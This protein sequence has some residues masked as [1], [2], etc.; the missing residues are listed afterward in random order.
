MTSMKTIPKSA[1]SYS[2]IPQVQAMS[3]VRKLG[4][5]DKQVTDMVSVL[6]DTTYKQ[7]A[8]NF[9]G[10]PSTTH[11]THMRVAMHALQ[12]WRGKLGAAESVALAGQLFPQPVTKWTQILHD[13]SKAA[14]SDD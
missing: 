8:E 6:I 7:A 4:L 12:Y 10:N 14:F 3:E 1:P 9:F 11:W 13:L 2:L 5:S